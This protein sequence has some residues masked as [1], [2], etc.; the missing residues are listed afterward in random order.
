MVENPDHFVEKKMSKAVLV[1]IAGSYN[2]FSLSLYNIK[3]FAYN[4]PEIRDKWDLSVIQ[5]R[6]INLSRKDVEVPRLIDQIVEA[7]PDLI[8]F[9]IIL[10][11][12]P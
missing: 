1:G 8:A 5:H 11:L 2:A 3:A 6:F 4:D 10:Y 9:L 7:N 12:K